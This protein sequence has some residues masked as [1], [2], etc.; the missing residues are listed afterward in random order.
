M[1]RKKGLVLFF[2]M[3]TTVVAAV[4]PVTYN[5]ASHQIRING[6]SNVQRWTAEVP[7]VTATGDFVVNNG[8]L[9]SITRLSVEVD[10]TAIRGSEGNIMTE[11]ILES[12]KTQ[13]HPRIVFRLTRVESIT[14]TGAEFNVVAAGTLNIAGVS[15]PVELSANGRILANGD[16]QISGVEEMKMTTW[17]VQPPRAMLGALRTSDDF[18]VNFS[19]TLK[20]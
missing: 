16:I 5:A 19:V 18:S 17:N 1:L 4:S 3:V 10:A 2:L 20:R 13:Q 6:N 7:R 15:R 12:L 14:Q 11:K 8:R 9:E